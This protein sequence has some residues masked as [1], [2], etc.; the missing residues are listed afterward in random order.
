[1]PFI[2]YL[3]NTY[4]SYVYVV[5]NIGVCAKIVPYDVYIHA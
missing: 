1:V 2:L 3:Y 4:V 5:L